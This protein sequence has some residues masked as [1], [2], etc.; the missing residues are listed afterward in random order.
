MNHT[1]Y[2]QLTSQFIDRE[3]GPEDERE[4]FVHLGTCDECRG[5]LKAVLTMQGEILGSKPVRLVSPQP[6][7]KANVLR[8]VWNKR[9]PMPVAAM[10]AVIALVS[11]VAF[12][13]LWMRPKEK[14]IETTQEVVYVPRLPAIQ[15]V[16]FYPS[17]S[18]AKK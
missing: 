9:I 14:V 18:D 16:G 13:A 11:T 6:A 7:R 17:T 3:L 5:F 15:V 12:S 8:A 2:Q 1:H 4:L 10:F